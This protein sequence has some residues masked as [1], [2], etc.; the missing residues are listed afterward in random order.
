MSCGEGK[1][2]CACINDTCKHPCALSASVYYEEQCAVVKWKFRTKYDVV[3][4]SGPISLTF[5]DA[6]TISLESAW[7]VDGYRSFTTHLESKAVGEWHLHISITSTDI[8]GK[9]ESM[10]DNTRL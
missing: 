1:C 4:N 3:W 2:A 5:G 9:S 7:T 8:V 6:T 10:F